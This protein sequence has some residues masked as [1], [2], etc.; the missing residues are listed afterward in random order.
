MVRGERVRLAA[1]PVEREH[2]LTAETL[3]QRVRRDEALELGR[4]A[5]ASRPSSSSAVDAILERDEAQLLE[6][7]D[8]AL[9]ERLELEVGKRRAAPERERLAE[10]ARRAPPA[11]RRRGLATSRSKRREVEAASPLSSST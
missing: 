4:R 8:L 11:R 7:L 6:S 1:R 3:A 9:G 2:Q 5:R 10:H